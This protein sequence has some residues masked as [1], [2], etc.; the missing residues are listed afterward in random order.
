[1]DLRDKGTNR[2]FFKEAWG[3]DELMPLNSI[4]VTPERFQQFRQLQAEILLET[5]VRVSYATILDAIL[6]GLSHAELKKR[7]KAALPAPA[8]EG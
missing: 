3:K 8:E 5:G 1:M 6:E 2:R 7:V 4:R